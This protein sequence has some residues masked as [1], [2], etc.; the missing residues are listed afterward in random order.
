MAF[1]QL[2]LIDQFNRADEDPLAGGLW[3]GPIFTGEGQLKIVSNQCLPNAA[4]AQG[5]SYLTVQQGPDVEAYCTLTSAWAAS[6]RVTFYF[7]STTGANVSGYRVNFR[8]IAGD[9]RV[10]IDRLDAGPLTVL[11]DIDIADTIASGDKFGAEMIGSTINA[12]WKAGAGA[13]TNIGSATDS[14]YKTAGYTGLSLVTVGVTVDD[15]GGGTL[16]ANVAW[17]TA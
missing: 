8:N 3:S 13:W 7:R 11:N 1:P 6:Y 16:G 2:G 17:I 9:H 12:Y 4:L 10:I 14:T 15:F 5:N